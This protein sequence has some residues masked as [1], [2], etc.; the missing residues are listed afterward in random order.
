MKRG[1]RERERERERE[2]R[3][4]MALALLLHLCLIYPHLHNLIQYEM[5]LMSYDIVLHLSVYPSETM[6]PNKHVY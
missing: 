2:T 6:D 3:I 1:E 4:Q 5:I